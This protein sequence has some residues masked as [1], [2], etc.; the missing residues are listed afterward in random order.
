MLPLIF[1]AALLA[2]GDQFDL[3]C[4]GT[5]YS[6]GTQGPV[7]TEPFTERLRIDLDRRVWCAGPCAA[8]RPISSISSSE[9]V[10]SDQSIDQV[11]DRRRISRDTGYFHMFIQ[12][13]IGSATATR[14][15]VG[16]CA[17]VE[18]TPIPSRLF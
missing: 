4:S 8:P 14:R 1:S 12:A 9:L 11:T 6:S 10:L 17:R 16:H 3:A 13:T 7:T 2:P 5:L 15:A 18:F